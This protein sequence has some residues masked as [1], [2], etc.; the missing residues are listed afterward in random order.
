MKEFT[1]LAIE[2][3]NTEDTLFMT[4][5]LFCKWRDFIFSE[6]T[7]MSLNL[8]L[9]KYFNKLHSATASTL[10]NIWDEMFNFLPGTKAQALELAGKL[11]F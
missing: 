3:Y 4:G 2:L 9:Y 7:E 5:I 11:Y 1:F 6:M 8:L 10:R